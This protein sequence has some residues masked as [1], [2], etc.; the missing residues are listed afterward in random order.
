MINLILE[1]TT[2]YC[3]FNPQKEVWQEITKEKYATYKK[4]GHRVK[5]KSDGS[6]CDSSAVKD[7]KEK[8]DDKVVKPPVTTSDKFYTK[9][10]GPTFK[11]GC[12][13]PNTKPGSPDA[14][15]VIYKVQGCIGAK[16]DGYFGPKT[17]ASLVTATGKNEFDI[18][19]VD[20]I[21]SKTK[22][23]G[24]GPEEQKKY[25]KDLID[26][27]Q[28]Y[29][30]GV[31]KQLKNIQVYV[32]VIK[33]K[34]DNTKVPMVDSD[35]NTTNE[36]NKLKLI[37]SFDEF[38]YEILYPI[39]P[40]LKLTKGE[41][42]VL[43]AGMNTN[44]ELIVKVLKDNQGF[45]SP[46]EKEESLVDEEPETL[47]EQ[48]IRKILWLRLLEQKVTRTIGSSSDPNKTYY[49]SGSSSLTTKDEKTSDDKTVVT[50]KEYTDEEKKAQTKATLDP[51]KTEI[52]GLMDK[53]IE[54][55]SANGGI[56][57]SIKASKFKEYRTMMEN[58]DSSQ[59]CTTEN[60]NEL[61]TTVSE[62]EKAM[63]DYDS[64]LD[65]TEEAYLNEIKKIILTIPGECSKLEEKF[66]EGIAVSKEDEKTIS[67][68]DSEVKKDSDL[69]TAEKEDESVNVDPE[70][71]TFLESK[72][73]T[74][75]RPG[76][77]E[78]S[79]LA[80]KTTVGEQLRNF[81]T[82]GIYEEYYTDETPIWKSSLTSSDADIEN[83]LTQIESNVPN[84]QKRKPCKRA[85]ET[86]Y[87]GAFVNAKSLEKEKRLVIED[88]EVLNG[89]KD[90]IIRCD[91]DMN[92][93]KNSDT[94]YQIKSLYL[95]RNIEDKS[96][97]YY[98][99]DR[100]CLK[101]YEPLKQ[102][103]IL[104]RESIVNKHIKMAINNKK[105]DT[106]VESVL[107]KIKRLK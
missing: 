52:L 76:L 105:K 91:E 25:W 24:F 46:T 78:K 45:W 50:K 17:L 57:K 37:K 42:G 44:D 6:A 51:K 15:G 88:D 21:C 106:M 100:F 48:M 58:F 23:V 38:D 40:A 89:L 71:K 29:K 69:K 9:C 80:T 22:V 33:R 2:K 10:L 27:G 55:T 20:T 5:T 64:Q 53:L 41:V 61:K 63:V 84:E 72:G 82:Y 67:K 83:M 7:D 87:M 96:R 31:V 1:A 28:V 26:N 66:K 62:L 85:I 81:D 36:E 92:F 65:E 3:W 34:K 35:I 73:F 43:T 60:L 56:L 98:G 95:C 16:Q 75:K 4:A 39:D 74:F 68:S 99:I 13:D 93:L 77:D 19:D 102:E 59:A 14:A 18:K 8:V 79:K 107:K 70:V 86:L 54:Y 32:Y 12:K 47:K 94:A 30:S 101:D 49:L 97:K 104:Q 90:S 11:K 103:K